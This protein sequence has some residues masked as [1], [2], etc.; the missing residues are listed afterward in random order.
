MGG[1][2]GGHGRIKGGGG[3]VEQPLSELAVLFNE[4]RCATL[5]PS[6]TGQKA[7]R[8]RSVVT[9][10]IEVIDSAKKGAVIAP[11]DI[12]R[13]HRATEQGVAPIL[14][15]GMGQAQP[16]AAMLLPVG[17]VDDVGVKDFPIR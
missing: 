17:G 5:P 13:Q 6:G 1:V 15:N 3:V 7:G 4:L 12:L 16:I 14:G 9:V 8:A 2:N 10:E 11:I